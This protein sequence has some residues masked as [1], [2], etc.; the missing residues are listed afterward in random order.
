MPISKAA[1]LSNAAGAPAIFADGACR[2]AA[3]TL[4]VMSHLAKRSPTVSMPFSPILNPSLKT[5]GF[6][7]RSGL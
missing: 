1:A 3:L 6:V 5:T 4:T 2:T 7:E